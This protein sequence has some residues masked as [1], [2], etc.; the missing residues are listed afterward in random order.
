MRNIPFLLLV[1]A[2]ILGTLGG[3]I[4][5][6][7]NL[8]LPWVLGSLTFIMFYQGFFKRSIYCPEPL[9]QSGFLILGLFFGLYFTKQTLLTVGPYLLPYVLATILLILVSIIN[10]ILVTKWISVDKIT[11]V[12]GSIPGGLSEMVIASESLNAKSSLVIIFQTV[13]LLTVLFF[14]PFFVLHTFTNTEGAG[15]PSTLAITFNIWNWEYLWFFIPVLFGVLLRKKIPAGIIIVP[16]IVTALMNI[17]LV[18]LPSLPSLCMIF[19]QITVGI[20]MGKSIAFSDLKLGGKY[21]FVYFGLTLAL[22]FVSF[23]LGVALA[24]FTSLDLPTAILSVAPGGLIEMVLTATSVGGDPAV[25]SSLQ[26]I[27]LLF[28]ITVVPPLLKWYFSRNIQEKTV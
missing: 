11:S 23:G 24:T 15:N 28:I 14:V 6:F 3:A 10:S 13:R 4:F 19:A 16:L 9:R 18:E 25:V 26:L 21:C 2:Y 8:P 1:E 20:G 12:F 17:F 27:R 7:F 22:I 5:Y